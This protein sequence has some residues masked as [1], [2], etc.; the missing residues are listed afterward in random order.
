[1]MTHFNFRPKP[2]SISVQNEQTQIIFAKLGNKEE[3]PVSFEFN[4][5]QQTSP[6]SFEFN[7]KQQTV[8]ITQLLL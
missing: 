6:V 2:E 4:F 5:K 8:D 7:F 1:M 3:P